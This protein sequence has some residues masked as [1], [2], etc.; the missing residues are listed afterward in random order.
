MRTAQS[1][2]PLEAESLFCR[3]GE[4]DENETG[5]KPRGGRYPTLERL[6]EVGSFAVD[7]EAVCASTDK[8]LE[9][10]EELDS[11]SER[12]LFDILFSTSAQSD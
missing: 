11:E 9:L 12:D 3:N 5:S 4:E 6:R 1:C 7:A 10:D 8:P 2:C